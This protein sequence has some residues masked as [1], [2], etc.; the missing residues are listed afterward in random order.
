MRQEERR[1][2]RNF[3]VANLHHGLATEFGY[4][5]EW[6]AT[7]LTWRSRDLAR[8]SRSAAVRDRRQS[9]HSG[10]CG[11]RP[12]HR[13]RRQSE[14]RFKGSSAGAQPAAMCRCSLVAGLPLRTK[15]RWWTMQSNR[16]VRRDRA[17]SRPSP[18][19]SPNIRLRQC[20][21]VLGLFG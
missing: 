7:P 4:P 1:R 9:F 17:A 10:D 6:P 16:A 5:G 14:A 15:P 11:G 3:V 18:K 20:G 19:R 13:C 12:N 21:V 8:A 2:R